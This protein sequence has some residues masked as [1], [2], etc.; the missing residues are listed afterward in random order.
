MDKKFLDKNNKSV[1]T[2]RFV[3]NKAVVRFQNKASR[4]EHTNVRN[5]KK[6]KKG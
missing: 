6:G 1:D 4:L 2:D 5:K 3:G